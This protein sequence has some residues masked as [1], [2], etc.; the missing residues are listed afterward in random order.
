MTE[1][2]VLTEDGGSWTTIYRVEAR[3]AES[4]IRKF[5][6]ERPQNNGCQFVAVP[7]RSWRPLTV[8][9]ETKQTLKF[10]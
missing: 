10:S 1:Y 2:I 3:S 6:E 7:A 9:V 4:A 8:S 5:V